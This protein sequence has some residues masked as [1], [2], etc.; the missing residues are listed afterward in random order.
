MKPISDKAFCGILVNYLDQMV[1]D[2]YIINKMVWDATLT[3]LEN[4]CR[5]TNPEGGYDLAD[6]D[7]FVQD[8]VSRIFEWTSTA[9]GLKDYLIETLYNEDE[10]DL[11]L[12]WRIGDTNAVYK[13]EGDTYKCDYSDIESFISD[14]NENQ[15]IKV[16]KKCWDRACITE[17]N[18]PSGE[19]DRDKKIGFFYC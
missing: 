3:T 11:N 15:V 13:F 12:L 2:E 6:Y 10:E 7:D 17:E 16:C 5:D 14:V 4:I 8:V 18:F 19:A 9:E 1:D